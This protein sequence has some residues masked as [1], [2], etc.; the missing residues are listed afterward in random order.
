MLS[1]TDLVAEADKI[2]GNIG[3]A[4]TYNEPTVFFEYMLESARAAVSHGLKNVMVSNGYINP[5]PLDELLPC[6]H[7][8]NIDLK[9]FNDD[10]Y[11]NNAGA[12]LQAVLESL[13]IIAAS[14]HH[15]EITF[16][17]IPGLN[18]NVQEFEKMLDF[19]RKYCGI[20]TVLHLSRYFP[21]YQQE[22]P[23]T[24]VSTLEDFYQRAKDILNFVYAGNIYHPQSVTTLCPKCNSLLI[25]RSTKGVEIFQL[26][27]EDHDSYRLECANCG[28]KLN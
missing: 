27:L 24:P 1:P 21:R 23:K 9:A 19:I 10:F 11:R 16:L 20:N 4:F 2:P 17:I 26:K 12:K 8:F 28:C 5:K 15:L 7:A 25:D 14:G 13:R 18:D 6:I 22:R 3:L